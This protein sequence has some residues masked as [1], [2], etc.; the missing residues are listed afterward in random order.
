[1]PDFQ[2]IKYKINYFNFHKNNKLLYVRYYCPTFAFEL[3]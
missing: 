3:R 1:M 2:F